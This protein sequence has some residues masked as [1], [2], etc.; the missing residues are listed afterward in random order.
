[1][2]KYEPSLRAAA[3]ARKVPSRRPLSR[4]FDDFKFFCAALAALMII[5][6]NYHLWR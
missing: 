1:L 5:L 2:R 3:R 4:R 6:S